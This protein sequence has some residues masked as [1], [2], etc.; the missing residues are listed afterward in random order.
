MIG[1]RVVAALVVAVAGLAL[2]ACGGGSSVT[3]PSGSKSYTAADG[4]TVSYDPA[5][6]QASADMTPAGGVAWFL[7]AADAKNPTD[8]TPGVIVNTEALVGASL[9]EDV[10]S[11]V[12]DLGLT[13][14]SRSTITLGDGAK[15]VRIDATQDGGR[16][17]AIITLDST[18][19]NTIT[20]SYV[21]PDNAQFES[22]VKPIEPYLLTVRK[23]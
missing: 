23:K 3:G 10:T 18:G 2:V 21:A 7:N 19:K 12:A 8:T 1:R 13:V 6:V 22:A 16:L 5:W 17:L 20:A 14:K 11:S 4:F 9:E 15:A